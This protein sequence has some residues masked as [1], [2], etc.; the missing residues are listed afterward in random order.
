[1]KDE[2]GLSYQELAAIVGVPKSTIQRNLRKYRKE[3]DTQHTDS[4]SPPKLD[5]NGIPRNHVGMFARKAYSL[6]DSPGAKSKI[7]NRE[8]FDNYMTSEFIAWMREHEPRSFLDAWTRLQPKDMQIG[9]IGNIS[10]ELAP[11]DSRIAEIQAVLS[12]GLSMPA[13]VRR[14]R[15]ILGIDK[16]LELMPGGGMA[17]AEE[18]EGM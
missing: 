13:Q 18:R 10:M 11:F 7:T 8:L 5:K 12:D 17:G 4:P 3:K 14:I 1:M 9:L 2:K 6:P 15:E 16:V